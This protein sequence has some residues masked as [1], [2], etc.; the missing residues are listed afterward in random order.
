MKYGLWGENMFDIYAYFLNVRWYFLAETFVIQGLLVLAM[1]R[2]GREVQGT[3]KV[4][5]WSSPKPASRIYG[6]S[7]MV[8]WL[9]GSMLVPQTSRLLIIIG[10]CLIIAGIQ[11][12]FHSNLVL[13][14]VW[15]LTRTGRPMLG[16]GKLSSR[17]RHK[18]YLKNAKERGKKALEKSKHPWPI[19]KVENIKWQ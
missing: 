3:D 14:G 6:A 7:S 11:L 10:I 19:I 2:F 16:L 1:I 17:N 12:A 8:M 4:L 9:I 18:M 15:Y 13:M 5:S